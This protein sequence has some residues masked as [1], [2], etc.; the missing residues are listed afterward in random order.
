M[1]RDAQR[2][3]DVLDRKQRICTHEFDPATNAFIEQLNKDIQ[4]TIQ[5][6]YPYID[7]HSWDEENKDTAAAQVRM[8]QSV[9]LKG[10]AFDSLVFR[11][12]KARDEQMR[13]EQIEERKK[14]GDG[15]RAKSRAD[16]DKMR[17]IQILD[18]VIGDH[19]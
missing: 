6:K 10:Y 11:Y 8:L 17:F 9:R 18:D 12:E 5:E 4:K 3:K 15:S 16:R 7:V 1:N 19:D 14:G 2:I 13:Y